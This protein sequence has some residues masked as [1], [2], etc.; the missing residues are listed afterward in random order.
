MIVTLIK[1]KITV[2]GK[3]R[4]ILATATILLLAS[5]VLQACSGDDDSEQSKITPATDKTENVTKKQYETAKKEHKQLVA[6]DEQLTKELEETNQQRQKL[7]QQ[8]NANED[9]V[10]SEQNA[11]PADDQSSNDQATTS[12]TSDSGDD[13]VHGGSS[14]YIIGNINSHVYHVPGQRGYTMKSKNA[15]YF[16]SEQEAINAGYR[17]A[18]Q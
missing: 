7:E 3:V 8:E 4:R 1:P 15:V 13:L 18:K 14:Q 16:Q 6:T 10:A 2:W 11:A 12:S 9:A 17:K 5:V